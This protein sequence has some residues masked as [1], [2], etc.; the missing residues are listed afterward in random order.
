V[1]AGKE[2][3]PLPDLAV[4]V[5]PLRLQNPIL[6]ASG[7]CGYGLELDRFLDLKRLGG[8][9]VKGLSLAPRHGNPAPRIVETPAGMLNSIGLQ[10]IGIDAFAAEKLPE[11]R[12][13]GVTVVANMFGF[14]VEEYAEVA[15]RL[16]R[17]EG[18][19]ALEIN[20]SCPN[21]KEGGIEIGSSATETR[22]VVAA[23]RAKTRLPIIAKLTPNVTDIVAIA[24]AA[25][26]GGAD[27]V[28]LINTLVGMSIDVRTRKPH[29]AS[30]TG[31]LSGPAIR[32]VAIAMVHKV[33][34]ALDLP[35][36]GCGGIA[37]LD[38]VLQFLI[39]GASAV[40]VGTA[41]YTDPGLPERLVTE[42]AAWCG[43]NRIKDLGEVI[44]SLDLG[45]PGGGD[46]CGSTG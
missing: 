39:A 20:I 14:T 41:T 9:V 10:N 40:E 44:G 22:K 36:V 28:T 37:S 46:A 32:P 34:A 17:L 1:S 38:D 11:L 16:D 5:G 3:G 25:A 24:R 35:I 27:A 45:R 33:R 12:A 13:R 23:V 21:V 7:T 42:L 2:R 43:E 31:G 26:D 19:A 15:A 29:L 4:Q 30:V 18:V 8:V 6:T